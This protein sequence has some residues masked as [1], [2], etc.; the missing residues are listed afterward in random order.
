M[1]LLLYQTRWDKREGSLLVYCTLEEVV[2]GILVGVIGDTDTLPRG[3]TGDHLEHQDAEGP[4]VHA[5]A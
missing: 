5:E 3:P 4:P 2:F 1:S